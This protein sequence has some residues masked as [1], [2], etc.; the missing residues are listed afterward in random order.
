MRPIPFIFSTA[1]LM[2]IP[3]LLFLSIAIGKSKSHRHDHSSTT[4]QTLCN[5][6]DTL[7]FYTST[8]CSN[9]I[10]Y[11]CCPPGYTDAFVEDCVRLPSCKRAPRQA[12]GENGG[13]EGKG[14]VRAWE[15]VSPNGAVNCGEGLSGVLWEWYGVSLPYFLALCYGARI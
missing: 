3:G 12:K 7:M 5:P 11:A 4:Q 14:G 2:L 8:R 6:T 10:F 13:L 15:G 1:L 9:R